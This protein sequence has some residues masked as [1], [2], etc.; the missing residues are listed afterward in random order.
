[1]PGFDGER[2]D[3]AAQELLLGCAMIGRTADWR[4]ERELIFYP[5]DLPNTAVATLCKY[6]EERTWRRGAR[7][8][9]EEDA[10]PELIW[11]QDAQL[12]V[13]VNGR[14][15]KV[16]L[17]PLSDFLK[18]FYCIAYE[19]R[20][21]IIG[22]NL[23]R[24]LA[25]LASDWHEVKK[26]EYVGAWKLVLWTYQDPNTGKRRP[27][28]G[29]RPRIILK[30][31]TPD[32]TFITFAERR[33]SRYRG[34]FLDLANLAHALTGRHW[35]LV[36]ALS[37]FTGETVERHRDCG[38]ITPDQIDYGRRDAHA[39]VQLAGSLVS[40]FDR[41]H[42]VSRSRPGGFVS[43]ARLFSPGGL[44]RAYFTAARISPPVVPNDRLGP[45][46]AASLGG[47]AEVQVRGRIPVMLGDFRREYQMLFLLQGL[48]EL[49]TAERLEFVEDTAA[50][51]DFV[52]NFSPDA[53]FRPETYPKL[54][55]LCWIKPEGEVLIKRAAFKTAS[56]SGSDRFVMARGPRYGN[57]PVCAYLADVIAAKLPQNSKA[58]EIIRAE[59]IVPIGHQ[60]LRRTRLV[61]G[62]VF[63]PRKHQFARILV[64]EG[65]R[66][67]QGHGN[68]ADLPANIR[69]EIVRGIKAIGNIACFGA[70][71][72]TRSADLLPGRREEVTL[73]S[74]TEP[75]RAA[76]VHPEEP[77][78]FACPPIAGLVSATGRLLLAAV[79]YAV[80]RRG[81]IVAAGDTDGAHIVSTE[82]GGTVCVDSRGADFYDGGPAQP[83]HALSLAEVAEV[84]ALFDPLNP[85]DRTLLPGSPLRVKG[86]S[87]GLFI[88]AKRYA[89]TGPDDNFIDRKE[90]ILGMLQPPFA[91]WIDD[92]WRTIGEIWDGRSLTPRPW[93]DL[94][95]M[96]QL[97]V[98]SPAH[99]RQIK[100]LPRLRPWN[101]VLVASAVGRNARD[102][103]PSSAL[104]V[105]AFEQD[106]ERWATLDWQ[107]AESGKPLPLARPD[108]DGVRWRL[109]T[110]REFLSTYARHPIPEMLAPDGSPCGPFTRGV[111]RRR[112]TR[113]GEL[114][115]ILKEAA[116]WGDDPRHAFSAPQPEK[117]R[118]IRTTA[119][120]DWDKIKP[121][122]GVVGPAAVA[123][124]MGLAER[125]ARAWAA[126]TRQPEDPGKV[127][128]AIVAVAQGAGLGLPR[129][130]HLRAEEICSDLPCRAAAVQCFIAIATGV[131]AERQGGIRALARAM[132]GQNGPDCEPALRRWLAV[133]RG[134]PRSIIEL[135]RIIAQLAKSSRS[136]IRRRRRRIRSESG[137]VGD[138]QVV[139]AHISLLY[140]AEKPLMPAPEETLAL[141]VALV[142]AGLLAALLR[143]VAE[144]LRTS[145][146]HAQPPHSAISAN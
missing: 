35:T 66:C 78:P 50:V 57:Q 142:L 16:Q 12:G 38:Q 56:L 129:D 31:V 36:D 97:S 43:E 133:P 73:L 10:E 17:L 119:S 33:G 112:P 83:V 87:E 144:G 3:P 118:A 106:P 46:C 69:K 81:G 137:P 89:L 48:Q 80:E 60:A 11:R 138:R 41:L 7:P 19:D 61:G 100:G 141:P 14:N 70:L 76:V 26:G 51:R 135:N 68:Y 132:A 91:G 44:A 122:L 121:A 49:L 29:W 108:A 47:W 64:E 4:V 27:S 107:F 98:T 72:E 102:T 145:Q 53:L 65:E 105:A 54:N 77:G 146:V 114:W 62:A 79:H 52:N 5:D 140:G 24:V 103:G 15:I 20:A 95:A 124:K 92:A 85:F 23:P 75:V 59:R 134:G 88:S 110:L 125:S 21:L 94:P 115:L 32:V 9:K 71:S 86:A 22:Y 28:A 67:D 131:L 99:A 127:A 1:M 55:V 96:R 90:S 42:P 123:R 117:I 139:L 84:A 45:C 63:D 40:L 113:D 128:R 6:V 101:S 120:V 93:F 8:R 111:L 25:R 82:K 2:W 126:G 116:V 37:T 18:L 136:E 74:D 58:P 143:P 104:V 109:V 30:R 130:E 13:P 34:E 39:T